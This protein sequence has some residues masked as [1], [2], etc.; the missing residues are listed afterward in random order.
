M[1][2]F[3]IPTT[4]MTVILVV[5]DADR[6]RDFYRDVLGAD[7]HR[8]YGGTSVVCASAARGSCW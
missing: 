4:E 7:I 3:P 8:E 2:D 5:A 1:A 6:A